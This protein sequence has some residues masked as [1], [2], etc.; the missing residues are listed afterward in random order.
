MVSTYNAPEVVRDEPETL[1]VEHKIR[2][3]ELGIKL[4]KIMRYERIKDIE[5][6]V[7]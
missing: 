4:I 2:Y 1:I 5:I 3:L 6:V 7:P